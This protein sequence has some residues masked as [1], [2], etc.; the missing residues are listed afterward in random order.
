MKRDNQV[1]KRWGGKTKEEPL[2]IKKEGECE[3]FAERR[4]GRKKSKSFF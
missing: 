3:G 1:K 2:L 4:G